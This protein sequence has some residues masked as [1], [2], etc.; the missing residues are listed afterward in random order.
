MYGYIDGYDCTYAARTGKKM[1]ISRY[2]RVD[3]PIQFSTYI[4]EEKTKWVNLQI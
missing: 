4:Q 1:V 3:L 2:K